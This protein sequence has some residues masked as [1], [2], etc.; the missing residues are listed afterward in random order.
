MKTPMH[1]DVFISYAAADQPYA[2]AVCAAIE[3]GGARCWIA[4]RNLRPSQEWAAQIVD[5]IAAA[6]L[7]VLVLTEAANR[8]VQ[9]RREVERAVHHNVDVLAVRLGRFELSRSLEYFISAWHWLDDSTLDREQLVARLSDDV[10]ELLAERTRRI[11]TTQFA[12]RDDLQ[13][14]KAQTAKAQNAK[15]QP[16]N[17]KTGETLEI[18]AGFR[19]AALLKRVE[20][21]LASYLGPIAQHLVKSAAARTTRDEELIATLAD[22]IDSEPERAAFLAECR[23][24][25]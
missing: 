8:S 23:R 15:A 10:R 5:A 21:A 2:F 20:S 16:R 6:D 4:P 22:E 9:V 14:G 7:V 11:E 3:T 25:L 19:Q 24:M 18:G 17:A 1:H 13:N 12:P